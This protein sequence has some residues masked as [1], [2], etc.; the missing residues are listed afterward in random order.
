MYNIQDVS[1]IGLP[2]SWSAAL[3]T[4]GFS[5]EEISAIHARRQVASAANIKSGY[6]RSH[7]TVLARSLIPTP[8]TYS[9]DRV[10]STLGVPNPHTQYSTARPNSPVLQNPAPRSSSLGILRTH[11]LSTASRATGTST[12]NASPA[13]SPRTTSFGIRSL[14]TVGLRG[15]RA[16]DGLSVT[17]SRSRSGSVNGAV[18]ETTEQY[19]IVEGDEPSVDQNGDGMG[20]ETLI[21]P[22]PFDA[23]SVMTHQSHPGQNAQEQV[24]AVFG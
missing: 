20:D 7:S 11:Q 8:K 24:S 23:A 9:H 3:S 4:A 21:E 18:G 10:Q 5:E 19:V 13:P 14:I 2:P 15:S 6:V 22:F 1:Y 16:P 17:S 12:G